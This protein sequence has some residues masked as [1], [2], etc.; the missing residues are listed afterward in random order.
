MQSRF[1]QHD[2]GG[3]SRG[4]G[5]TELGGILGETKGGQGA[6]NGYSMM[7]FRGSEVGRWWREGLRDWVRA[8]V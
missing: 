6:S 7:V 3:V 8:F 2:F 5:A 1:E 4:L